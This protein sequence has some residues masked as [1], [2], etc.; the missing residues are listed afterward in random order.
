MAR[1]RQPDKVETL[2]HVPL[3][4]GLDE[5]HLTSIAGMTTEMRFSA[6]NTLA[7]EGA[8]GREALVFLVGE[9]D[10]TR[11]GKK[12]AE[13]GPGEVVGEMS[14]INHAPRSATVT[15]TSDCT[16]LVMDSREFSSIL[17]DNPDVAIRVLKTVVARLVE[18]RPSPGI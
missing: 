15:A 18:N 16:V 10:V 13:I 12:V 4:A 2:R 11:G 5:K 3:F 9:A 17:E 1:S 7:E 6:G 8:L 14:L